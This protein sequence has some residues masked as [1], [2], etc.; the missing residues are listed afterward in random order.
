MLAVEAIHSALDGLT[1]IISLISVYVAARAATEK[2]TYGYSR[3]ELLSALVSIIA[4]GLL[5]FKLFAGAAQRLFHIVSGTLAPIH[6]EGRVVFIAEGIT[7]AANTLMAFVLARGGSLNIR[8]LRAHVIADSVENLVVLCAGAL[9]WAFPKASIIDPILTIVIV[10]VILVMN[11]GIATETVSALM[12]AAPR[13]T[14]VA[15]VAARTGKIDGVT[16]IGE[17]HIWAL[18]SGCNIASAVVFVKDGCSFKEA[19]RIRAEV[20]Q[21]F[22]DANCSQVTVQVCLQQ[23]DSI[24]ES[25]E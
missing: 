14:D 17:I 15:S 21:V 19:E 12:Q 10:G 5:C 2:F 7:L 11:Y 3:A 13:D 23:D 6:V 1:V 24:D 9:M 4:L 18:T 20:Q 22:A 16:G 25:S 8:A